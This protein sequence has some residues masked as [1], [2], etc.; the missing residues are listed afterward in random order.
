MIEWRLM[1]NIDFV[2]LIAASLMS[3]TRVVDKIYTRCYKTGPVLG[4][5]NWHLQLVKTLQHVGMSSHRWGFDRGSC[6]EREKKNIF[7]KVPLQSETCA[8]FQRISSPWERR[9]P[10]FSS[11]ME[12]AVLQRES[13][14][15]CF[16]PHFHRSF[17]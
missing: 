1:I 8:R 7:K 15:L 4:N 10:S 17:S 14:L 5:Y 3:H 2:R 13:L 12:C 16:I 11:E 6:L 9:L